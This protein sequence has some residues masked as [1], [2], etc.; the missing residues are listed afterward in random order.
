MLLTPAQLVSHGIE[1]H[2]TIR[3]G[4]VTYH[5]PG[6]L[7]AYPLLDLA[8]DRK[9]VRKFVRALE[10]TMIRTA[11]GWGVEVEPATT[12]CPACGFRTPPGLARSARWAFTFPSG[13][14]LWCCAERG[15]GHPHFPATSSVRHQGQG[16]HVAC[17]RGRDSC[18]GAEVALAA[19]NCEFSPKCSKCER[20]TPPGTGASHR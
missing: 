15:A 17:S 19:S 18:N 3:G 2:E 1:V 12:G 10:E 13:S 9:D 11:A 20:G 14:T 8:P 5:G 16:R 4:E 7:V 6:Q